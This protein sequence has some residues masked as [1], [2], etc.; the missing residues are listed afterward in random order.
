MDQSLYS[1]N[2]SIRRPPDSNSSGTAEADSD[3]AAFDDD[4]HFTSPLRGFEHLLHALGVVLYVDVSNIV[5]LFGVIRTGRL[6]VRSASLSVDQ[7]FFCHAVILPDRG[8]ILE[9]AK[10]VTSPS[11]DRHTDCRFVR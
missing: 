10:S 4:G 3:L 8:F 11:T 2:Y 1:G 9:T 6:G 7:D 5:A